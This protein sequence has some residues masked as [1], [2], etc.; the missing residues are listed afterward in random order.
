MQLNLGIGEAFHFVIY[1]IS[2]LIALFSLFYRSE[3]GIL[4]LTSL[5]PIYSV[6]S[7]ALK[8]ELPLA[9]NLTDIAC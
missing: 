4:F 9:N 3:I 8:S 2:F 7:K 6:Y 1:G 5:F